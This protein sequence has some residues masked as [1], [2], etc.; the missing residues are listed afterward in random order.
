MIARRKSRAA[1]TLIRRTDEK[2]KP[3]SSQ[4]SCCPRHAEPFNDQLTLVAM[5]STLAYVFLPCGSLRRG[6]GPHPSRQDKQVRELLVRAAVGAAAVCPV[7]STRGNKSDDRTRPAKPY[8]THRRHCGKQRAGGVSSIARL[9]SGQWPLVLS[10]FSFSP[11]F[12]RLP[13]FACDSGRHQAW[14]GH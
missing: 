1:D 6:H 10:F 5:C 14:D 9:S 4:P 13:R 2:C 11:P 7:L 8:C 3:R 12:W